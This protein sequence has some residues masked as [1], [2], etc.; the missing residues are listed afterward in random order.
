MLEIAAESPPSVARFV[1]WLLS[2]SRHP[3]LLIAWYPTHSTGHIY[4]ELVFLGPK[5]I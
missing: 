4:I 2:S 3:F 1:G 5:Q